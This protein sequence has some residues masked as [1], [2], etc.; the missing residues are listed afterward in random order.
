MPKLIA[1]FWTIFIDFQTKFLV[2][3]LISQ[4]NVSAKFR[5]LWIEIYRKSAHC[6]SKTIPILE[7][8][9]L[10][11]MLCSIKQGAFFDLLSTQSN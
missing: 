3:T 8:K 9:D 5:A 1:W 10:A 2:Q 7:I 6:E 4:S 11:F